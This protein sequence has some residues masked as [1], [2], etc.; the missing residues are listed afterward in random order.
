MKKLPQSSQTI[1]V[2]VPSIQGLLQ[3]KCACGQHT[4][5][6]GECDECRK[7]RET[8]VV[9]RAPLPLAEKRVGGEAVPPIVH[10]VLRSPGHSLDPATRAFMEPR[11]GHDFSRVKVSNISLRPS[12]HLKIG[13]PGDHY[14]QEANSVAEQVI[15][16][17]PLNTPAKSPDFGEVRLHT[18]SRAAESAHAVNALAYTVGRDIV[19]GEGQYAPRTKA[20]MKL[21][22]HELTHVVQQK[23]DTNLIQRLIREPYP[24]QGVITEDKANISFGGGS[25]SVSK[26]DRVKVISRRGQHLQVEEHKSLNGHEII[27]RGYIHHTHVDDATSYSMGA[28]VGEQMLYEASP[29][30]FAT[31]ASKENPNAE[32]SNMTMNCWEAVLWSAY[33]S[34]SVDRQWIHN[35]YKSK[36]SLKEGWVDLLSFKSTRKPYPGPGDNQPKPQRGDIVFFN[37]MNHVA[38]ATGIGSEIYSFWPP[39]D[40]PFKLGGIPDKV[41]K[42]TIEELTNEWWPKKMNTNKKPKVEFGTPAW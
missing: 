41:R 8:D 19:F 34:G 40:T 37:G 42:M 21:L 23:N 5:A 11:F 1:T 6:G 2:S 4:V 26:G 14:E 39:P 22:A 36:T 30:R 27:T 32:P 15:N 18:D 38:L 29:T 17:S 3:R 13:A 12:T 16:R 20:G 9:Q 10:E 7:K 33:K 25:F 28:M 24:W 31:W 35:L